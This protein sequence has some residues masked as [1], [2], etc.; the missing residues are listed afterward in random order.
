MNRV[1]EAERSARGAIGECEL[2]MQGLLEQ[3]RQERRN[4]LERAQKRITALHGRAA[5]AL[6]RRTAQILGQREAPGAAQVMDGAR[7]QAAIDNLLVRLTG[8]DEL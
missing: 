8:E 3:A 4:I 7:L 6:E 2:K 1:L 5:R